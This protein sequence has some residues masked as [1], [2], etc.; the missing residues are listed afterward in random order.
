MIQL[1]TKVK[2]VDNSGAKT[3]K[4]IKAK[5]SKKNTAK[6]GNFILVSI[7]KVQHSI[8]SKNKKSI[9][10]KKNQIFKGLVLTTKFQYKKQNGFFLKFAENS[11]VL[12]D[13]NDNLISNRVDMVVLKNL[14]KK[15]AKL[16]NFA[17]YSI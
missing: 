10:P 12:L 1:Q 8:N 2:I 17:K 11:V 9:K 13:K 4:C 6:I 16:V 15:V 7:K 3:A 5:K 14:K